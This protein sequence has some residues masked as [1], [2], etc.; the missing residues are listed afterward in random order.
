MKRIKMALGWGIAAVAMVAVAGQAQQSAYRGSGLGAAVLPKVAAPP[1]PWAQGD[2]GDSLYRQARAYL[3]QAKYR[4]AARDFHRLR[5]RFPRSTYVPDAYYWEAYALYKS[6]ASADLRT[7]RQLLRD[8]Q[9]KYPDAA[10]R[11]SSRDLMGRIQVELARLGDPDATADVADRASSLAPPAPPAGVRGTAPP[12]PP[13]AVAPADQGEDHSCNDDSDDRLIAL[14][15]LL[16]MDAD[17]AVPILKQVLARRDAGSVCLRRKAI[18]ILSQKESD[19]TEDILLNEAR[20]DPDHNVREQAVFWLSQVNTPKAT[21]ALDSILRTATDVE[22]QKKAVF[23]LSQQDSPQASAALRAYLDR[24]DGSEDVKES[25]VFWLGQRKSSENADYLRRYFART[26]NE[27][28]KEKII[29]SLSQMGTADNARW[30]LDLATDAKQP[31][32][33]RKKALFWAGQMHQVALSDLTGLYDRTQSREMKEQ[34]IF[35]YSQRNEPAAVDKLM[36]I[37]R[38]EPDHELRKKAIFWLSQSRD[39]RVQQ[40]LLEMINK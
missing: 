4:D 5:D 1:A 35:V 11:S 16:Q 31:M 36:D 33:I 23:A 40:F 18:F 14:G 39:P 10:G 24:A 32:E 25:V 20:N 29:F 34:L 9:S 8:Q 21:A 30:L 15:A 37:A 19:Q 26:N 28:L 7:A 6:G 3:N 12:A 38:H 2:P 13:A 17:R 27:S 22:L